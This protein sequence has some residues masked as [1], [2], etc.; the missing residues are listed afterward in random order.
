MRY[1][2]RT[3]IWLL[4]FA[5]LPF[6][7]CSCSGVSSQNNYADNISDLGGKAELKIDL[8]G[9]DIT[10]EDLK[11]MDFPDTLVEINLANTAITDEGVEELKRANSLNS[12]IL[13]HTQI[14]EKS[15]DHLKEMPNLQTANIANKRISFEKMI[16]FTKHLN[17]K[18]RSEII[19]DAYQTSVY[20]PPP[21]EDQ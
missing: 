11:S 19:I 16:E 12:V 6:S 10:D 5:T 8:S 17:D 18:Q 15:L 4:S 3:L 1:R 21:D 13:A 9:S 2:Y 20:G 14:T 7:G